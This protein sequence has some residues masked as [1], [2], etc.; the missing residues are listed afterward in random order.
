[1][2]TDT[3]ICV[4]A[5]FSY[6]FKYFKI[7]KENIRTKGKYQG[8]IV[9]ITSFTAPTF[10]FP[11]IFFDKKIKIKRFKKIIFSDY[12]DQKLRNLNTKG[13]PNRHLTKQFQ[14]QKF[15]LFDKSMKEWKYIFYLDINMKIHHD[16]NF[17][18]KIKPKNLLFARSDSYP[19]YSK[20]LIS[21]FDQTDNL[22]KKLNFEFDLTIKNYF[23]TGIL[24]FDSS[25]I[26]NSTIKDLVKLVEKY[27]ITI[28]NEQAIMNL[29]FIY[30]RKCYKELP[31]ET[32][33][34]FS[35][36]YWKLKDKK[37]IIT[38]QTVEQ[39]K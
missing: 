32:E 12:A 6:L 33:G 9:I 16:I 7:F 29:Y 14:W 26:K 4:V 20:S 30:I 38:K 34:G 39:Y 24:Y 11:S 25:I 36:Y 37:I 17:I 3:V 15:N 22:I 28:T 2:N 18:L 5:D 27:P 31:F 23:Q 21:Q 35:Y 13:Q 10:L 1:M 8:E 19:E